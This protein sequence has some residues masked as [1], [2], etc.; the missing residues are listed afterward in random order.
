MQID[1]KFV[2]NGKIQEVW[3]L[4]LQPGTLASCIPGAEKI[5]STDNKTYNCLVKQSVGPITVRLQFVVNLTEIT[6]PTYVKAVGR[7]EALGK[8]GTFGI[9]LVVHLSE[10]PGT[11]CAIDYKA[12]VSMVGKLATFG[13]R[14]MRAKVKSVGEQF[15]QNLEK[16][17]KSQTS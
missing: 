4:V 16:K 15:T 9:E 17:I 7:G 3:D 11:M 14:I 2:V 6:P 1:G 5:E 12:D 8:L 13:E 10:Q